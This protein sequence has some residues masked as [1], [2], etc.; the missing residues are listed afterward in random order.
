MS[1]NTRTA[2]LGLGNP[3]LADD[4]VGVA[5]AVACQRLLQQVPIPGVDV[6][7]TTRGGFEL[8]DLLHGY[9]AAVLIDCLDV[10][11]PQPGR[12]RQLALQDVRGSS[13]LIGAHDLSVSTAFDLAARLSIPMPTETEI[14]AVEGSDLRT[15]GGGL[16]PAVAS[17]VEPLARSIHG[18]LQYTLEGSDPVDNEQF[19]LRRMTYAPATP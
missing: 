14:F 19:R 8:I 16:S 10:P 6:L 17:A 5:V 13:R 12:V 15:L 1:R 3:L 2:I 11:D 7:V 4:G 18:R 9:G